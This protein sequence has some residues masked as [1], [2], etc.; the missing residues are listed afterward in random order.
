MSG[1]KTKLADKV[2]SVPNRRGG[3]QIAA[4]D[5]KRSFSQGEPPTTTG[6]LL[7]EVA[8]FAA[9][10]MAFSQDGDVA[11]AARAREHLLRI[12]QLVD[13]RLAELDGSKEIL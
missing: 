2:T 3:D 10:N 9:E 11:A 4:A 1:S 5:K 12:R 7:L 6:Q 13:F 8:L